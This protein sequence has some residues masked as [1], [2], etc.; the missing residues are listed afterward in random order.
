LQQEEVLN[1]DP[2][3]KFLAFNRGVSGSAHLNS[4]PD[5][6]VYLHFLLFS[7][8]RR[9]PFKENKGLYQINVNLKSI[10]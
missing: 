10:L 5:M 2:D 7:C 4:M 8:I 3:Q 1:P 6:A 9:C